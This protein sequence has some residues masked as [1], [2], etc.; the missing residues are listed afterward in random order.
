MGHETLIVK[1][2]RSLS[3]STYGP[4]CTPGQE[5]RTCSFSAILKPHGKEILIRPHFRRHILMVGYLTNA[6][7]LP[8]MKLKS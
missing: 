2:G 3:I 1:S 6:A 4:R 8:R 5:A 7:S